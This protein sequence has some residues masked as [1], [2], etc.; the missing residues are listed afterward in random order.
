LP[1]DRVLPA[2]AKRG[3]ELAD[4]ESNVHMAIAYLY[5]DRRAFDLA[6]HHMQRAVEIN[7]ANPWNQADFGNLLTHIGRAEEGLDRLRN[8]R[9]ADP[10]FG[11]SWYWPSLAV[12]E[13]VLRRCADAL[14]DFDRATGDQAM[15]TLAVMA[16]CCGK[17]GLEARARNLVAR[18]IAQQPETTIGALVAKAGFKNDTDSQHLA[19]CLRLAGMPE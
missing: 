19:E 18:C 4:N 13:F 1:S 9:R 15:D 14:A 2:L 10:Y 5:L 6:L 11:P 7:P 16:G 17:L 12:A 8:A 3:V